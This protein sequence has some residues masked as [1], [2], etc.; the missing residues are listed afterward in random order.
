MAVGPRRRWVWLLEIVLFTALCA[1]LGIRLIDD[2]PRP[3]A[4][5]DFK[6]QLSDAH[7]KA[8]LYR[9]EQ[10]AFRFVVT[11]FEGAQRALSPDEFARLVYEDQSSRGSLQVLFN[12][13]SAQGLLW[14]ALGLAGQVLFTGRLVVQWLASERSGRSVVPPAFWWMS[15]AGATMLL[16]YFLWRKDVVGVLGQGFG[17]LVY[18]RNLW[19]IHANPSEPVPATE[20][21][22]PEP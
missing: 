21:P 19:M 9:D 11:P 16:S 22:A 20:D 8:F 4:S 7:D 3:E 6:I 13:S 14:V 10:G 5:V 12:V 18:V 1:W 2:I 17:W 15:L